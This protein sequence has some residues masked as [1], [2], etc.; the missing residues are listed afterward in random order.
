MIEKMASLGVQTMYGHLENNYELNLRLRAEGW[1]L[2][3]PSKQIEQI[4]G[5]KLPAN[6]KYELKQVRR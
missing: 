3:I 2:V 5:K 4:D 6:F 1:R